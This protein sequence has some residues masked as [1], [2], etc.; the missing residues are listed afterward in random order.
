MT[1]SGSGC[2]GGG[3]IDGKPRT[4]GFVILLLLLVTVKSEGES[5]ADAT[6]QETPEQFLFSYGVNDDKTGNSFAHQQATGAQGTQGEY[7]VALPDGRTQVVSYTADENGYNAVVTYE[8]VA[9]HPEDGLSTG[10]VETRRPIPSSPHPSRQRPAVT[11]LPI[12]HPPTSHPHEDLLLIH[13]TTPAPHFLALNPIFPVTDLAIDVPVFQDQAHL[14]NL[15]HSIPIHA[16]GANFSPQRTPKLRRSKPVVPRPTLVPTHGPPQSGFDFP[17]GTSPR[18]PLFTGLHEQQFFDRPLHFPQGNSHSDPAFQQLQDI[19]GPPLQAFPNT[20]FP[21]GNDLQ[22][23]FIDIPKINPKQSNGLEL[24]QT[25]DLSLFIP[26]EDLHNGNFPGIVS[27]SLPLQQVPIDSQGGFLI[28]EGHPFSFPSTPSPHHSGH[29]PDQITTVRHHGTPVHNPGLSPFHPISPV[30]HHSTPFSQQVNAPF[31]HSPQ[32]H[33][34]LSVTHQDIPIHH[35]TIPVPHHGALVSNHDFDIPHHGSPVPIHD[36]GNQLTVV[37]EHGNP[38]SSHGHGITP[39]T[40]HPPFLGKQLSQR[41]TPDPHFVSPAPPPHHGGTFI[42]HGIPAPIVTSPAQHHENIVLHQGTPVPHVTSA[43]PLQ[44]GSFVQHGIPFP[45]SVSNHGSHAPLISGPVPLHETSFSHHG[46]QLPLISSP[47][48]DLDSSLSHHGNP[49]PLISSPAPHHGS[50]LHG[51]PGPLITSPAPHH[52]TSFSHHGSPGPLITSPA[53]HHGSSLHG[54]PGPLIT[55]P[56]PHHATSFSHHGSPGPLI[57]SPAPH[58]ESS[59]SHHGSPVN[60]ISSPSQHHESSHH[61]SP[62]PLISSPAPHHGTSFSHFV[63]PAPLISSPAPHHGSSSSHLVSHHGSPVP[64]ISSP[65]PLHESSIS[66]QERPIPHISTP[67]PIHDE[68]VSHHRSPTP[69]ISSPAPHHQISHHRSHAP[70]IS[71]PAPHHQISHHKSLAPLLSS[72]A[73]HHEISHHRSPAPLLS[74][75]APH[76]EISHHGSPA[77]LLSSPAPHHDIPGSHFRNSFPFISSPVPHHGI[78]QGTPIP[79][80]TSPAPHHGSP[81]PHHAGSIP[82]SPTPSTPF[83]SSTF[84][85][86]RPEAFIPSPLEHEATVRPLTFS[87][88]RGTVFPSSG[89]RGSRRRNNLPKSLSPFLPGGPTLDREQV[90]R[91]KGV[92]RSSRSFLRKRNA[93]TNS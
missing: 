51:S 19:H 11:S 55:S 68:I 53:P 18:N 93:K 12:R 87:R 3:V 90:L 6:P 36:H 21:D 26:E 52:A 17:L 2:G 48:P 54:S 35:P 86:K 91:H 33:H 28:D 92:S 58:H 47:V 42:K 83:L 82:H 13:P 30:P 22:N 43:T 76:H 40:F 77:P 65:A 69:I 27:T 23:V 78:G 79:H 66:H 1:S 24:D 46:N 41:A 72:P 81:L 20:V 34:G 29:I 32:P 31:V 80:I 59:F 10:Q 71:S 44:G 75:P 74:S 84:G 16:P 89:K 39:T 57:T 14:Q 25:T 60:V 64:L 85:P 37:S 38:A 73:P 5:N 63:S 70:L 15:D 61:G 9:V 7:R 88:P 8:G 50:S 56:A 67:F 4:S 62:V 49:F 45:S